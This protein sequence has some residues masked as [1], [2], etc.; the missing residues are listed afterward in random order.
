MSDCHFTQHIPSNQCIGDSLLTLNQNFSSLDYGLCS[1]P[2]IKERTSNVDFTVE[3]GP[4]WR[5]GGLLSVSNPTVYSTYVD[6]ASNAVGLSTLTFEDQTT[7]EAYCLE[8]NPYP[9]EDKPFVTMNVVSPGDGPPQLTVYWMG[10]SD[11]TYSTVYALNSSVSFNNPFSQTPNDSVAAFCVD[12]TKL[13]VGGQ[14]NLPIQKYIVYN[15][16]TGNLPANAE[17]GYQGFT[18]PSDN[19]YTNSQGLGPTG[20]VNKILKTTINGEEYFITAGTFQSLDYGRSLTIYNKTINVHYPFYVHGEIYDMIL[21]E[22]DLYV[23]GSFDFANF[24]SQPASIATGQRVYTN[25]ILK[26]EL[27][28]LISSPNGSIDKGFAQNVEDLFNGPA[29]IFAIAKQEGILYIGGDFQIVRNDRVIHQ[30][31]I[32][33]RLTG[34]LLEDFKV[35]V[36][37]PIYTMAHDITLGRVYMGG[38]FTVIANSNDLYNIYQGDMLEIYKFGR[39]AV[40]I[41]TTP[42]SPQLDYNWKPQFNDSICKLELHDDGSGTYVYAIGKFTEVSSPLRADS[43]AIKNY[44]V[45]HAAAVIKATSNF[46]DNFGVPVNWGVSIPVAPRY[47][48]NALLSFDTNSILIG[49]AFLEVNGEYRNYFARVAKVGKSLSYLPENEIVLDFGGKIISNSNYNI[50]TKDIPTVRARTVSNKFGI[51]NKTT[52]PILEK[53]FKGITK[54]QLCRLFLRRPGTLNET[55]NLAGTFDTDTTPVYLLGWSVD[56]ENLNNK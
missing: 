30:N 17:L 5:P 15:T 12:G 50:D 43:Q 39:A 2:R 28:L 8:N 48:T 13:H 20:R 1:M 19:Q 31:L 33:T 51:V 4:Q 25:G 7:L 11:N 40:L 41:T 32:A 18:I 52:F 36:N 55:S 49:G 24:S 14:F 22:T 46:D 21:N 42:R 3:F 53:S 34:E 38:A 29:S 56:F 37:K 27:D 9:L 26:I 47:C 44:S 54:N 35:I 45:N 16:E 23:V 10:S 6:Y